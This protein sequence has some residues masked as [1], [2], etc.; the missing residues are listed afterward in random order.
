MLGGLKNASFIFLVFLRLLKT[1]KN[2]IWIVVEQLIHDR[3][4]LVLVAIKSGTSVI[5]AAQT[6]GMSRYLHS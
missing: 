3:Y 1:E 5:E 4:L 2:L 6:I